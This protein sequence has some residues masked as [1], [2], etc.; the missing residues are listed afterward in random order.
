M[1]PPEHDSHLEGAGGLRLAVTHVGRPSDSG[2]L[3]LHGFGQ[4]R[5]AW[6]STARRLADHGWHVVTMDL[7]GHGDSQWAPSY[8]FADFERD[9]QIAAASFADKPVLVGASMG[10]ILSLLTQFDHDVARAI[11]LVDVVPRFDLESG[12]KVQAFMAE[13]RDGFA[14]LDDAAQAVADYL[15]GRTRSG[16]ATGLLRNL[17]ADAAGRLQWK[18]DPKFAAGVSWLAEADGDGIE[19]VSQRMALRMTQAAQ[20]LTVPTLLVRGELSTFV[21]TEAADD[22]A[23]LVPHAT[24][25]EVSRAG[26]MVAGDAND[27]FT[28][29]IVEFLDGLPAVRATD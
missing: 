21:T 1:Q 3:L 22:F 18:W 2:V 24:V 9:V 26:H 8:R 15:P 23:G 19:E 28:Q 20:A 17:R 11:A 13:H 29:A 6:Q 12:R 7:R 25:V 14:T 27:A 4:S 10:G 16:D 5:G